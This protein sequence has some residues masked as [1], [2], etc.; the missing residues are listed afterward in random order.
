MHC[1]PTEPQPFTCSV[2]RACACAA[3]TTCMRAHS[4]STAQHSTAHYMHACALAQ[5]TTCMR[6]HSHSTAQHSTLHAC[7]R[8]SHSEKQMR[9]GITTMHALTCACMHT[10]TRT[11]M[12]KHN[13]RNTH[14]H[15]CAT[16][17]RKHWCLPALATPPPPTHPWS[18]YPYLR[19]QCVSG[20]L[21]MLNRSTTP[22][23]DSPDS[24]AAAAA[25]AQYCCCCCCCCCCLL[26]PA[27]SQQQP[28]LLPSLPLLCHCVLLLLLL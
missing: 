26:L 7:V 14:R 27:S 9:T 8:H 12:C 21:L 15:A 16:S 19:M 10:Q 6:A 24:S 4:H 17:P 2:R 25:A 1:L 28:L 23:Q 13:N 3:H 22:C 5:H 11:H 18:T 20:K